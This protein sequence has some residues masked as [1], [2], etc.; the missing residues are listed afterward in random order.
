MEE[1]SKEQDDAEARKAAERR[2]VLFKGPTVV[3]ALVCY[4][5]GVFCLIIGLVTSAAFTF[6]KGSLLLSLANGQTI[7][8]GLQELIT[9]VMIALGV[10]YFASGAMLW[11]KRLWIKGIYVGIMVSIVGMVVSAM[12]TTFAP[13]AAASG[14]VINV[15]IV[16]LLATE[17]WEAARGLD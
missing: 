1:P 5:A 11:S 2:S 14:M 6:I 13:G 16:T 10:A 3:A 8:S 15:L 7:S 9:V 12:G 4:V 17:T